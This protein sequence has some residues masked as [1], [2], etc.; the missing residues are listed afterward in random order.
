MRVL[1]FILLFV[2]SLLTVQPVVAVTCLKAK[3][4][5]CCK[6]ETKKSCC[7]K[8]DKRSCKKEKEQGNCC[9]C[10]ICMACACCL[11]ATMETS[12]VT[13]TSQVKKNNLA[14]TQNRNALAGFLSSPF[15]P[16]EII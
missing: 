14:H 9:C 8:K 7:T 1:S 4:E 12:S 3:T 11:I 5:S 6:K 16:P 2:I 13:F 15:Q 10:N